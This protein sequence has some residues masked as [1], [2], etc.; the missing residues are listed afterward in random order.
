MVSFILPPASCVFY[1][2]EC[3]KLQSLITLVLLKV[4]TW[5]LN[6][7]QV[8][9]IEDD[10]W[11]STLWRYQACNLQSRTVFSISG[12]CNTH[13]MTSQCWW[14][15]QSSSIVKAYYWCKF[16]AHTSCRSWDISTVSKIQTGLQNTRSAWY[17]NET[18]CNFF[19]LS[20]S[21]TWQSIVMIG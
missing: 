8:L 19:L 14:R 17:D 12:L 18:Y 3:Q 9:T 20:K 5:N 6:Q 13:L 16:G 15:R 10:W 4:S 1:R 2:P 21:I 7:W 11:R